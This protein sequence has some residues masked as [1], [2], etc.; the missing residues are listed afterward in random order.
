MTENQKKIFSLATAAVLTL[1][2]VVIWYSLGD[3][4]TQDKVA[5]VEENKLSSLSPMQVIKDEFSKAFSNFNASVADISST[6]TGTTTLIT[7]GQA[8]P[9]E[10]IESTSTASTTN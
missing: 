7:D 6:T 8:I 5:G 3:K 2:I 9:I 4:S 10:I 1:I